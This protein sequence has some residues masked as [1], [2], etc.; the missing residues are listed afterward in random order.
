MNLWFWAFWGL[1]IGTVIRW[2]YRIWKDERDM[3]KLRSHVEGL[4]NEDTMYIANLR[5]GLRRCLILLLEQPNPD[6]Y[7]QASIEES[8]KLLAGTDY[9]VP[10]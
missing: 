1:L 8:R 9:E 7:T 10:A 4:V 2:V 6:E 3:E 5:L